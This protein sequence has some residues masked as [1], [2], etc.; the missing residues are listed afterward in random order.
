[1]Q[2]I[3][4]CKGANMQDNT[5]N[6]KLLRLAIYPRDF[7]DTKQRDRYRKQVETQRNSLLVRFGDETLFKEI[8]VMWLAIDSSIYMNIDDKTA[9]KHSLFKA[10]PIAKNN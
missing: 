4:L 7:I 3:K 10:L 5:E 1:M 2:S 8:G 9:F 6:F